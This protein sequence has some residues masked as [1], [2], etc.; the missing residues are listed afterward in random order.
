MPF[1]ESTHPLLLRGLSSIL[2]LSQSPPRPSTLHSEVT[3]RLVSIFRQKRRTQVRAAPHHMLLSPHLPTSDGDI[4]LLPKASSAWA[5]GWPSVPCIIH[6]PSLLSHSSFYKRTGIPPVQK[7]KLNYI[8][9][10]TILPEKTITQSH[11]PFQ[12]W[13]C[14][15]GTAARTSLV[16][17]L[18]CWIVF[19]FLL[20]GYMHIILKVQYFYNASNEDRH[21]STPFPESQEKTVLALLADSLV[22]PCLQQACLP[23]SFFVF[24]FCASSLLNWLFFHTPHS[25]QHRC[26]IFQLAQCAKFTLLWPCKCRS[27]W[28]T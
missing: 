7:L 11:V 17:V 9:Q 8:N 4:P 10:N 23:H 19:L 24:H 16:R 6:S 25:S 13:P 3:D 12:L 22:L 18:T 21:P 14:L 28:S 2:L 15:H 26:F 5:Q 20:N 27:Q 1:L